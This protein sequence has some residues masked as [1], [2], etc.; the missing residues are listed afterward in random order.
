MPVTLQVVFGAMLTAV[1]VG[2]PLGVLA[3]LRQG[4]RIDSALTAVSTLGVAAPDFWIGMM[5]IQLFAIELGALPGSGLVLVGDDPIRGLIGTLLPAIAL[6]AV[7]AS[8]IARQLR[9]AMVEVLSS[10][11]VRTHRAKGLPERTIV[12][13]RALR[14]ASVPLVTVSGLLSARFLGAAVSVEVVFGITGVGR[15][16]IDSVS[17]R[18]YPVIQGLALVIAMFVLVINLLTDLAYRVIDPRL[19]A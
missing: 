15:L 16:I 18:D 19:R 5:L 2:V 11:F 13:R 10:D 14:N 7:G 6:G 1:L 3:A 17:Q 9:G 12:W 4:S 8:E